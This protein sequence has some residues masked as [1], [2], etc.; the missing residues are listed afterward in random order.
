[1]NTDFYGVEWWLKGGIIGFILALPVII[2]V[3]KDDKK[4]VPPMLVMST[5]LGIVVSSIEHF[6]M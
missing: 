1:M 6:F 3:A 5:I 4:S 2:L